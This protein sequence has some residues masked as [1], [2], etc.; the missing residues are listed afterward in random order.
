MRFE[1]I[2]LNIKIFKISNTIKTSYLNF[3]VRVLNLKGLF[4]SRKLGIK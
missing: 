3:W 1:Y 4:Y 2:F